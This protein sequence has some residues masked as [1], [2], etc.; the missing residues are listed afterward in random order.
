MKKLSI[1]TF[2]AAVFALFIA[3][4]VQAATITIDQDKTLFSSGVGG[5]FSAKPSTDLLYLLD[6]Y[7]SKAIY[8]RG[9]QTFCI[10]TDE[11]ISDNGVYNAT[12]IGQAENGG[13]NTNSGDPISMGAAYLYSQFAQGLLSGYN[14]TY[15][16]GRIATAGQLQQAFWWLEGEGVSFTTNNTFMAMVVNIFGSEDAA[17][18]D[19][20]GAYG[21]AV[22][23]LTTLTGGFAQDQLV[24]TGVPVPEPATMLLFGLGLLGLA[25]IRRKMKK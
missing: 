23:H 25:G 18:A 1:L 5:E 12:I 7:N 13:A 4:G 19:S 20:N 6:N 15:G 2:M 8:L 24:Y 14:Y 16:A 22:L 11:Y 3:S 10:E 17:K 9:F 21:V